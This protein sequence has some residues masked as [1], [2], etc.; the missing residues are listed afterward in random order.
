MVVV[1]VVFCR[2]L[3]VGMGEVFAVVFAVVSSG[4]MNICQ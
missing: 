2:D 1:V 3:D 4:E